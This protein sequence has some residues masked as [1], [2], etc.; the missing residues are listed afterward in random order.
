MVGA[1]CCHDS[2]VE[3]GVKWVVGGAGFGLVSGKGKNDRA[4]VFGRLFG[5]SVNEPNDCCCELVEA[6]LRD[7]SGVGNVCSFRYEFA[8]D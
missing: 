8:S 1:S 7:G 4:F 5:L 2:A 6:F 3:D